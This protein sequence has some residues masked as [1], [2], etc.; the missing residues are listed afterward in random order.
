MIAN[1]V[2]TY[3][4]GQQGGSSGEV[5]YAPMDSGCQHAARDEQAIC[6]ADRSKFMIQKKIILRGVKVQLILGLIP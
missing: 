3:C 2:D 1:G 6:T 5:V 4:I